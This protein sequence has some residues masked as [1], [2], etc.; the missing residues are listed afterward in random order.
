MSIGHTPNTNEVK[1]Q[2][3]KFQD[4]PEEEQLKIIR[5]ITG[6]G[7]AKHS[8]EFYNLE[9]ESDAEIDYIEDEDEDY[10]L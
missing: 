5:T 6:G 8:W 7:D 2:K 3:K 4:E 10:E 9:T 1:R